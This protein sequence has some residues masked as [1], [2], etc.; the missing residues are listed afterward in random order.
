MASYQRF[1]ENRLR[2]T[3]DLAGTPIRLTL[4]GRRKEGH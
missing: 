1:L 2:E 3:F 4:R